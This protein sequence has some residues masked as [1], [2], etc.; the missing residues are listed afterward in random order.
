MK[1]FDSQSEGGP[2]KPRNSD[3]LYRFHVHSG[4]ATCQ[5]LL[6]I[7]RSPSR[8]WH[9]SRRPVTNRVPLRSLNPQRGPFVHQCAVRDIMRP[10]ILWERWSSYGGRYKRRARLSP[11]GNRDVICDFETAPTGLAQRQRS[12]A[13]AWSRLQSAPDRHLYILIAWGGVTGV[14]GVGKCRAHLM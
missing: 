11:S 13:D 2:L 3:M 4:S 10:R 8:T 1:R 9:H 7:V 14:T 12:Q 5:E 6:Y